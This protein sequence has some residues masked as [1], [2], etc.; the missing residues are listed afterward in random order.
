MIAARKTWV[1]PVVLN[2]CGEAARSTRLTVSASWGGTFTDILLVSAP[3]HRAHIGMSRRRIIDN[4]LFAHFIT[5][6]CYRRR[7]L[8]SLDHPKRLLMGAL[9]QELRR[10]A[11]RC[12]GFLI[13]PDH[14]HAIVWFPQPGRLSYFM[15]EWKRYSSRVIREWYARQ[16]MTY[17]EK[18]EVGIRFWQPKYHSF[19]TYERAKLSE[20]LEY[21]HLNPVR[22]GI[23]ERAVDWPW[24]SAR[25]Y[26]E[27]RSVGVAIQ[28]V[29]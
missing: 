2:R 8:L 15:H 18:A 7:R 14:V 26:H 20:K 6:A 29:E 25:W 10:Q 16:E 24:S 28:A 13:M 5:F 11:A 21:M 3:D 19:E 1:P 22:L 17:F 23:V 9:N 12:V 4:E 27:G